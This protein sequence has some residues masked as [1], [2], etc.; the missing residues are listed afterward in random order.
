MTM[1]AAF[2][3]AAP[4]S[5]GLTAA[6]CLFRALGDP[7]RL[8]ILRHLQLGPHR[9]VDLV[10]HLHLAQSTVSQHLACLRGCGLIEATP[11][12]RA[13]EYSIVHSVPVMA[14][15]ASAEQVLDATGEAVVLCPSSGVRG[16]G[17]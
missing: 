9:V 8:G 16:V 11:R 4:E 10:E 6:A 15:L 5:L 3:S 17:A 7:S 12:G 14:L 1:Q 2:P 13:S